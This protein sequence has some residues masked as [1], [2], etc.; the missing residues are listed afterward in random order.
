VEP[1]ITFGRAGDYIRY[2][3]VEVPGGW[4][5]YRKAGRRD[6]QEV[7][8]TI[9]S[10]HLV[11]KARAEKDDADIA[12]GRIVLSA[13][14]PPTTSEQIQAIKQRII[15]AKAGKTEAAAS[16]P[17]NGH[18]AAAEPA[19]TKTETLPKKRGPKPTPP[20]TE[21]E[22][23]AKFALVNKGDDGEWYKATRETATHKCWWDARYETREDGGWW[24]KVDGT[25]RFEP[26]DGRGET[27]E[28]VKTTTTPDVIPSAI[29][30]APRPTPRRLLS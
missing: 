20:P 11:L 27:V 24:V 15:D 30:P 25:D 19:A 6:W 23:R 4:R 8:D 13:E 18:D 2:G 21:G 9:Y 29:R 3:S 5:L 10:D 1:K 17:P 12:N 16:P 28:E 22:I 14:P 26:I 7:D